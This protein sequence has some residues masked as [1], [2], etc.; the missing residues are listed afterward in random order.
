[1]PKAV[2]CSL[3]YRLAPKSRFPDQIDDVWQAYYW[4]ILNSTEI[5]ENPP[6]KI[7]LIGDSAGGSL[8]VALTAMTIERKFR[9]P[10]GLV[11]C[12]ASTIVSTEEFW[13]SLMFSMDDMILT[14]SFLNL[15]QSSYT[16]KE[17]QMIG[18]RNMYISPGLCTPDSTLAQFPPTRLMIAGVDSFKDENYKL[19]YRLI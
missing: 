2:I 9:V 1:M 18:A 13:P 11:P 14:Q 16:P 17:D 5:F 8:V 19:M 12:Y 6:K 10:D 4:L 3:D 15:C 7:I